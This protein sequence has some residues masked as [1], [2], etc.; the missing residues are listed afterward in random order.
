MKKF[1]IKTFLFIF[2]C[3]LLFA[4]FS[5]ATQIAFNEVSYSTSC[6]TVPGETKYFN[7]YLTDSTFT[8][9]PY[10]TFTAA[11]HDAIQVTNYTSVWLWSDNWF[12]NWCDDWRSA[13]NIAKAWVQGVVVLFNTGWCTF[14]KP[15]NTYVKP[16]STDVNVQIQF[17]I[18]YAN[19]VD[20]GTYWVP[21]NIFYYRTGGQTNRT[22]YEGGYSSTYSW[23]PQSP[24]NRYKRS[25]ILQHTWEC[26]NYR[27]F[28]CGDWLLNGYNWSTSYDN[29]TYSE[30]CDPKLASSIPSGKI[31]NSS[32]QLENNP[33]QQPQCSSTYNN[34]TQYT[35]NWNNWLSQNMNLCAI[36]SV[37]NFQ[38]S[39]T[40]GG[41]RH[42]TWNCIAGWTT[43][44]CLAYQQW[45]GDG[46]VE[47][48]HWESC[49]EWELNWTS[50]HCNISCTWI[51][52]TPQCNSQYNWQTQ[53]TS[54]SNVWLNNTMNLCTIWTI[55]NFTYTWTP[56]H[57]TW[58]C[59][60]W[61]TT[62]SCN[63][64]QQ[65]CWDWQVN[66]S[67][68]CDEWTLYGQP[69]HCN[70]SCSGVSQQPQCN[71]Q[72]NWQTQYTSN[73]TPWL[74][75]TYNLCTIW[76]VSNFTYTWTPRHFTWN[77]TAGWT[78]VSCNANQQWCWDWQINGSEI[79]DE[80]TLNGQPGHCNASC[81]DISQQ[82]QCN[83]QYNWQTQYTSN[84]DLWLSNTM[85]LCS[86]WTVS[87][88]T[89][90]WTP[91][92]F[93]W[94]CIAGWT[95]VSCNANQQWCWDWQVNGREECD[96]NDSTQAW[97][98]WMLCDNSCHLYSP[99]SPVPYLLKQQRTWGMNNF[100]THQ[101]NVELWETII[102]KI[103][104]GNSWTVAA[105]WKVWDILPPCT[106]YLTSSIVLPNGVTYNWPV[107]WTY[108]SQDTVQYKDFL[109]QPWQWWYMLVQAKIRW[110]GMN[111]MTSCSNVTSY[112]NTWYF[113]LWWTTLESD[114]VAVR[115]EEVLQPGLD[116]EKILLTTWNFTP[117]NTIVYKII[118][119]NT[120]NAVY[121]NAYIIDI[122]PNSIQYST[123]SIQVAWNYLFTQWYTGNN[124]YYIKYY[125]FNLNPGASAVV[126]LTWILKEGY[127]YR[128]T[129]NCAMTSWDVDCEIF[130]P[131]PT[132]Y[133]KKWQ[134][135]WNVTSLDSNRTTNVLNVELLQ[136]ISYRIDFANQWRTWAYGEVKDILPNCVQYVSANLIGADWDGPTYNT[137]AHTVRFRNIYLQPWQTWHMMV[138][139]KIKQEDGCQNVYSY[140]NTWAFH[141][142]WWERDYSEVIAERQDTTDVEITKTVDKPTVKS[143]DIVTYTI[144]YKNNWPETLQTYTIVDYW[145]ND[146]LLFSWVVSM[147][148][149]A[150]N[151]QW[152]RVWNNI[153]RYFNTPLLVDHT[154]QI[155]IQWVVR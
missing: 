26:L 1:V 149:Q 135:I 66:W 12:V 62:V 78:T 146:K 54:N 2:A 11:S 4:W 113:N 18:W 64:N 123:S 50:G 139:W 138:V 51:V 42:F 52:E 137:G 120:G 129:T 57:F 145:P 44:S 109:L 77:C 91:R 131:R 116:I 75:N 143:G 115:P 82:P 83:S 105:T 33:N 133:V 63:A 85:R 100:T 152:E 22:C 8:Q 79:C 119:T 155:V 108:W 110:D 81:S 76:T 9:N 10:D 28:W 30:Q 112:L 73:S 59:V 14:K 53:Y 121:N 95:T 5:Y 90:T 13:S 72:Y 29:W 19:I 106:N 49:D 67:E 126:Y 124:D 128:E 71:S 99:W 6:S 153:K 47:S 114:V 111:W 151:Y 16:N 48:N 107:V 80:W 68:T 34:Q 35:S 150:T 87:D 17:T 103:N 25:G 104:F 69:G 60:A 140:L 132:P 154:W 3:T 43:V 136:Y 134:T 36:W 65:C 27:I 23:C 24:A 144:T 21:E 102:Y 94:N 96:P 127:D 92:H 93:T 46:K 88:F 118:L 15:S 97:W 125:N 89:Y 142:V 58:N 37:T 74:D 38:F 84:S 61:W 41:S 122:L 20:N 141:F 147:T 70:A 32:C 45:C 55:S 31:C 98:N 40:P 86:V 39:W 117:G 56:R 101:I 7:Y 148:P 130:V